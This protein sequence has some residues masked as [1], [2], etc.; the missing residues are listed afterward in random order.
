MATANKYLFHY[1]KT[2]LTP[3]PVPPSPHFLDSSS[4]TPL[5][6]RL[7]SS[8][9]SLSPVP[10]SCPWPPRPHLSSSSRRPR[11]GRWWRRWMAPFLVEPS[12]WSRCGLRGQR[13]QPAD[14]V[15]GQARAVEGSVR[16]A[17]SAAAMVD[18]PPDGCG[19]GAGSGFSRGDWSSNPLPS[20]D[21]AAVRGHLTTVA[22][23]EAT[24]APRTVTIATAAAT[25]TSAASSLL[26]RRSSTTA[27]GDWGL[28]ICDLWFVICDWGLGI[29]DLWLEL[30]FLQENIFTSGYLNIAANK[31][32][33]LLVVVLAWLPA[34]IDFR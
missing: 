34:K 24:A 3:F 2:S 8:P 10:S 13:I 22:R 19:S 7:T 33:F 1:I 27:T 23:R 14:S 32:L 18:R 20:P 12:P 11:Q 29:G 15:T 5:S 31:I 17:D 9:Q 28:G 25:A 21:D 4:S 16:M 30:F 26:C 6:L